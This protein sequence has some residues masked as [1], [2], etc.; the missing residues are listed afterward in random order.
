MNDAAV[1][2][3]YWVHKLL[4][5][6]YLKKDKSDG[7]H[8]AHLKIRNYHSSNA[9]GEGSFEG[10]KVVIKLTSMDK[11]A[12]HYFN[13]IIDGEKEPWGMICTPMLLRR[14]SGELKLSDGRTYYFEKGVLRRKDMSVIS[15][16]S[17][18]YKNLMFSW[19]FRYTLVSQREED[20]NP[21]L[22][23]VICFMP[24]AL[25]GTY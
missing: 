19:D 23:A 22:L 17:L 14:D 10:T 6:Y 12:Y 16:T 5:G 13:I 21:F 7:N 11:D 24:V 18:G 9:I 25:L 20:P 3:Y 4:S 1:N 15:E 8:F 2:Q